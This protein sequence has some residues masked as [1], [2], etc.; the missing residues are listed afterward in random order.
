MLDHLCNP[1]IAEC[2]IGEG[3]FQHLRCQHTNHGRVLGFR[4]ACDVVPHTLI[5]KLKSLLT[6]YCTLSDLALLALAIGLRVQGHTPSEK[7]EH[8]FTA[9]F[10]PSLVAF[11]A[12][13]CSALGQPHEGHCPQEAVE[14]QLVKPLEEEWV[15]GAHVDCHGLLLILQ[16]RPKLLWNAEARLLRLENELP[17]PVIDR[18]DL[19]EGGLRIPII[20]SPREW[21]EASRGGRQ[22]W[23]ALKSRETLGKRHCGIPPLF[24][25]QVRETHL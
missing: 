19:S 21:S 12:K 2:T 24:R 20:L 22:C 11:V 8:R 14:L 4:R 3:S 15:Q 9:D 23:L 17:R 16:L 25:D 18:K 7:E 1:P 13:D 6:K 5:A 10:L